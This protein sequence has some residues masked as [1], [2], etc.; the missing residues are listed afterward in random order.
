MSRLKIKVCGI[1][2]YEQLQALDTYP[3]DYIGHIYYQR[4]PRALDSFQL[5]RFFKTDTK[6]PQVLV[7][8]DESIEHLL[9]LV[10]VFNIPC[11]QLHGDESP[12]YCAILKEHAQVI[13]AIPIRRKSDFE[14]CYKYAD[15]VDYFLFDTKKKDLH[16]GTGMHW[17]WRLLPEYTADVPF[18]IS[19]G[20][21]LSDV[22][23][24]KQLHHDKLYGVD[25]NSRFEIKPGVKE[26]ELVQHF[27]QQIHE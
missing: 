19:G 13:K 5:Q 7:T 25:I 27:I 24:I 18:F 12:A 23:R 14:R 22:A 2:Q 9:E 15:V 3:V 6:T 10:K 21:Q 26:L 17:D 20:V 8:V 11:V 4:S 1:A 16:G